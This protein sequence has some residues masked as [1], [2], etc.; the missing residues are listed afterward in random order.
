M[1]VLLPCGLVAQQR[2]YNLK[3]DE[4]MRRSDYR[5]A[6]MWYEE[7]VIHCDAYSIHR[8][9]DIWMQYEDARPAMRN[10]MTKCLNCLTETA[11]QKDTVAMKQLILYY[12]EGIGIPKSDELASYWTGQLE[13]LRNP[14]PVYPAY[15]APSAAPR[16]PMQWFAGYAFALEAPY[17]I[18]IGGVWNRI[19]WYVRFKTNFSFADHTLDCNDKSE[20]LTESLSMYSTQFDTSRKMKTNS[21]TGTGGVVAGL[22]SWL[23]LSAGLGYGERGLLCPFTLT[24]HDSGSQTQV[25]CYNIDSSY[26]GIAAECDLMVRLGHFFVSAGANTINFKYVDLNAGL[27]YFF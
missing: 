3:G 18:T 24:K 16:P 8:L 10:L 20:I 5:D 9:T 21:F 26:K 11:T 14:A 13:T 27:G 1:C 4:A 22:A 15:Q 25:W 7:G 2:A 17:G 6:Q 23:Y 19:G 12:T